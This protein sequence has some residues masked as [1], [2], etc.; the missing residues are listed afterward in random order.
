MPVI[1]TS[2]AIGTA[3]GVAGTVAAGVTGAAVLGS[4]AYGLSQGVKALSGQDNKAQALTGAISPEDPNAKEK[5]AIDAARKQAFR[6]GSVF[7]SA[8]GLFG[9]NTGDTTSARL[10]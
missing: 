6:S 8:S 10:K 3:L 5:A 9:D 1:S 7:T 4:A 2:I